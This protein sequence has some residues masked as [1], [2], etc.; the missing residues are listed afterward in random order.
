MKV[1]KKVLKN[2]LFYLVLLLGVFV[3][4]IL[5]FNLQA[6]EEDDYVEVDSTLEFNVVDFTTNELDVDPVTVYNF[7]RNGFSFNDSV[8]FLLN[9]VEYNVTSYTI[10][11]LR[12]YT[13]EIDVAGE[14]YKITSTPTTLN[15][16]SYFE[17]NADDVDN[18]ENM[19]FIWGSLKNQSSITFDDIVFTSNNT[20]YNRLYISI[21]TTANRIV[22]YYKED[23]TYDSY[24]TGVDSLYPEYRIIDFISGNLY[25]PELIDTLKPQGTFYDMGK[26][27]DNDD[28]IKIILR[29]LIPASYFE[30]IDEAQYDAGI[31]FL[32]VIFILS[33]LS[34]PLLIS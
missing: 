25:N 24:A 33:P 22:K 3:I 5:K 12:E 20:I 10:N 17:V 32:K 27:F 16:Y 15:I 7:F 4:P 34:N 2:K 23:G 9:D 21:R 29:N 6:Q 14:T 1:F 26:G 18:L 30:F 13:M 28:N 11:H 31:R 8:T 19:R